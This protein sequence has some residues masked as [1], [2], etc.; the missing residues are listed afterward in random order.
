MMRALLLLAVVALAGCNRGA[1]PAAAAAP[2][3]EPTKTT[4]SAAA[5][6]PNTQAVPPAKTAAAKPT[7]AGE[8]MAPA[9]TSNPQ[10]PAATATTPG[11]T[12]G[13]PASGRFAARTREV[14]NPDENT[15]V[16][17]YFDLAG[18]KA[19]VEEWVE[20]DS[21]VQF[22]APIDKAARRTAVRAELE[23]GLA[24]VRDIGRLRVSFG[25][26]QLSDYDPANGEFTIGAL[27]PA[28]ELNF[29]ALGQK[30]VTR[31]TNGETTQLWRVPAAEAQAVRD[32]TRNR[33]VALDTVLRIMD[34][35]PGP[36]GGAI[37]TRIDGYTLRTAD[38]TTL[39]RLP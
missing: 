2:V 9:P 11:T 37:I 17:L 20:K 5:A 22:A 33:N 13:P 27:S 38:G 15:M 30:V 36:G 12:T 10:P 6:A 14:V 35:Q 32:R 16:F 34:V 25:N 19:P 23:A 3:P 21:R 26:A 24:A 39:A 8:S 4:Q 7:A 29:S 28:S 31:F 18:L 1:A